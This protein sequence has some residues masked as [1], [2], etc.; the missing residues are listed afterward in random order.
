MHWIAAF[1]R[2][3]VG[4]KVVMAATG[5]LLFGFVVVHM[6]GNLQVYQGPEKL[7][8]YAALLR[9]A[10]ALVWGARIVLGF[11]VLVH[12]LAAVQLTLLN[13]GSRP[14]KYKVRAYQEADYAART[15]L[16]SGPIIAVFIGY[17]LLHLTVGVAHPDFNPEDVYRNVVIGFQ[18]VPVAL[19]YV[20]ANLLLG[21]HL[22]HGLW[23][24]FQTLGLNHPAYNTARRVFA[25]VFAAVIAAGNVSIPVAVL[26]GLVK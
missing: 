21:F 18:V 15:M 17:R 22:Y 11:S 1:Y 3:T 26:T 5:I 25:A 14:V 7:N 6:L 13:W 4:K 24:L 23:S 8:H 10:P 2:S 9:S 12:I 20:V 16:W 19:T